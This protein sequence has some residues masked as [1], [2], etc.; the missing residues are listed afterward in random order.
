[1]NLPQDGEIKRLREQ[2]D[3]V[4]PLDMR[5]LDDLNRHYDI[6]I[7]YTS[8]AL[9]GSALT[10]GETATVIEKGITV[11]GKT[12][13]DHLAVVDHYD[14]MKW[15]RGVASS[16]AMLSEM[17][18]R[19][20]HRRI[21]MRSD[22]TIGGQY[23]DVPRRAIGS[24][25]I[26]PNPGKIPSLMADLATKLQRSPPDVE[27]ALTAH[28]GL[29]SIHPFRDGNGRVARLMM[30]LIYIRGGYPPVSIG[31]E[32]R[33]QYIEALEAHQTGQDESLYPVF[34]KAQLIATLKDY[35]SVVAPET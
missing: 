14:A 5:A 17:I 22:P 21:V 3:N 9:E 16:N 29:A 31:P 13:K 35:L 26:Y 23:A 6:H 18:I 27:T 15:M 24:Q 30:N 12:L 33:V 8:N 11:G 10:H 1:V 34:M 20:L 19:E 32:I 4:R 25:T 7:T 28:L 2:L